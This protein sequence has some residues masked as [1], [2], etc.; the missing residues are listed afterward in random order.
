MYFFD[1]DGTLLDSNGIWLDI[2]MEFL[3]RYGI[4][5]VPEEY[6]DYVTHHAFW[7]AAEYTR[8]CFHLPLTAE[9]IIQTWQEMA[10]EA[11]ANQLPLKPG[12]RVFLERAFQAGKRCVLI[13]S[14]IPDLCHAALERHGLAPF[15]EEVLT[16]T[17]MGLEKRDPRL[18]QVLAERFGR[19]PEDCILFDDSPIYCAAAKEAGWQI[20]GVADEAFDYLRADMEALCGS[21]FPFVFSAETPLP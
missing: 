13:T 3:G 9:E 10:R 17:G 1:L 18:F 2:D 11:Y 15:F 5:P 7:D 16:T 21:D 20:R 6:T 4:H 12:A 14:C 19:R 8:A